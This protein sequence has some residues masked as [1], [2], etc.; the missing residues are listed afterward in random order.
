MI[1]SFTNQ[2][3]GVGKTTSAVNVAATIASLDKKV[4]LVDFDPQGNAS[5]GVG[6]MDRSNLKSTYDIMTNG[7]SAEEAIQ[8]TEFKNLDLIPST[9]DLAGAELEIADLEARERILKRAL[10]AISDKYDYI[11][12]DCPPT[13]GLLTVNALIASEGLIIP[14]QCEFYALEGLVQLTNTIENIKA[15]H[16][17]GL[18]TVGILITMFN[19]RL[20]ITQSIMNEL[21]SYYGNLLFKTNI[22]RNVRLAEAPSYG[23]PILYLDRFSKGAQSYMAVAKEVIARTEKE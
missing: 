19:S 13:L 3:G 4:L 7:L 2:K 20:N 5:T 1:I 14:V 12:I 22:V 9:I 10:T 23:T 11:F 8:K 6:F 18:K 15:Y 17:P 16:N 21:R